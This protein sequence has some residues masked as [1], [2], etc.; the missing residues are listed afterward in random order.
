MSLMSQI[1][2][3]YSKFWRGFLAWGIALVI[4]GTLAVV[5]STFTTL[6][7]VVFLGFL[8]LIAG[9]FV[10]ID[11]FSFWWKKGS[12]FFLHLLM[13]I[14]YVA[15][16]FMLINNPV[17]SSISLTLLLGIFY[18]ALGITRIIYALSHRLPMWGWNLVNGLIALVLGLLI[19]MQ[20]PMTGLFVIGLFIGI[21][22]LFAG[23]AYIM[24]AMSAR[25]LTKS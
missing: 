2:E 21:D 13:G 20:W 12:G 9:I 16:G 3:A 15:V 24:T 25:S 18:L 4:L 22:L 11:A 6:L 17:W 7:S 23:W 14:L 10:I 8:I 19:L 1:G 5:Y